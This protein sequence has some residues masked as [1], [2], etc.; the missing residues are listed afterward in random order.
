MISLLGPCTALMQISRARADLVARDPLSLGSLSCHTNVTQ[1]H[2]DTCIS[3]IILPLPF[4]QSTLTWATLGWQTLAVWSL[5]L[6][7]NFRDA[8]Q[9]CFCIEKLCISC[10]NLVSKTRLLHRRMENWSM[11]A[12]KRILLPDECFLFKRIR[13]TELFRFQILV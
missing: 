4:C 5:I 1:T 13:M 10:I 12:F 8:W 7:S 9:G 11:F 6:A 2:A 3:L